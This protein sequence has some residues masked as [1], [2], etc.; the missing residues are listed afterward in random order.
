MSNKLTAQ[1]TFNATSQS[2]A[3]FENFDNWQATPP[4]AQGK[5]TAKLGSS[6]TQ[7][8]WTNWPTYQR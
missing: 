4:P 8:N 5:G 3:G 6:Q 7:D 2:R 1:T